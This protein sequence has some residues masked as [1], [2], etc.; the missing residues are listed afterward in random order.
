MSIVLGLNRSKSCSAGLLWPTAY[1]RIMKIY[2]VVADVTIRNALLIHNIV[3]H[4]VLVVECLKYILYL[5]G[6]ENDL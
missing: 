3:N 1:H 2:F 4:V 5:P 6:H